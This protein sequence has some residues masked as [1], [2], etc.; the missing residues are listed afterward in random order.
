M[1]LF[2]LLM[3]VYLMNLLIGLLSKAI[4][5]DN[6]RVSYLIQK[7]KVFT[8]KSIYIYFYVLVINFYSFLKNLDFDRNRVI[9]LTST[10]KT[11]ENLVP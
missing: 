9:L 3:A 11:L 1:T 10:S 4:K 2:S 6:N 7:A 8:I 5:R